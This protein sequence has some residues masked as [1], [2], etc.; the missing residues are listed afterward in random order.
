MNMNM[1]SY[2]NN[3][4]NSNSIANGETITNGFMYCPD[5]IIRR[6]IG[7]WMQG[8]TDQYTFANVVGSVGAQVWTNYPFTAATAN[9]NLA[10]RPIILHRPFR[11]VGEL[12]YVLSDSPWRNLDCMTPESGFT[13]LFDTFCINDSGDANGLVTGKVDLNTRQTNVLASILSG[14]YRDEYSISSAATTNEATAIA[15]ALVSRTTNTAS[16]GKGP[17]WNTSQLVGRWI[18]SGAMDVNSSYCYGMFNPS[19]DGFSADLGGLYAGG[20]GTTNNIIPR[21]RETAMRAL[22]DSGQAGTWNL[23]IDVVAQT[24]KYPSTASS[25][26]RFLVEGEKRFWVHVAIDRLT[27]KV[28]DESIE[29]VTE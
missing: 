22:L 27:G 28:L 6:G 29:P 24:G 14:A 1:D 26:D 7:A 4:G 15:A 12:G 25:L 10:N 16:L 20:A 11:N 17:I 9:T 21:Y 23:L 5:G 18:G 3:H 13:A 2:L 8:G 19:Y